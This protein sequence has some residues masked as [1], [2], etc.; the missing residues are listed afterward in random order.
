MLCP[1]LSLQADVTKIL[2][3]P[4]C[5]LLRLPIHR[6]GLHYS[7][8]HK[9]SDS[10]VG[11]WIKCQKNHSLKQSAY[12]TNLNLKYSYLVPFKVLEEIAEIIAARYS[13]QAGIIY[14]CSRKD[15]EN[16]AK[17]L[18][19]WVPLKCP[20]FHISANSYFPFNN[21]FLILQKRK[22]H[23]VSWLG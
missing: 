11:L 10:M 16:V 14:C 15:C 21:S 23:Q 6:P 8:R 7:V 1:L 19:W 22:R 20:H 3:I 2:L 9:S 5:V 13:G 12:P 4:A 18:R 17:G